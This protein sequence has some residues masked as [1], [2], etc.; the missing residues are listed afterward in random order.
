MVV[1]FRSVSLGPLCDLSATVP[2]GAVVG[3]IALNDSGQEQ[4]LQLA[5]GAAS[6]ASGGV[7]AH[8]PRRMLGPYDALDLDDV[9]TVALYHTLSLQDSLTRAKAAVQFEKMRRRGAS[10]LLA[11]HE[12]ELLLRLCDEIWWLEG[13]RLAAK[14]DPGE[15]LNAYQRHVIRQ[16]RV[17]G[18]TISGEI[19]PVMRRVDGRALLLDLE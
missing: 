19:P 12:P 18:A 17:W 2:D 16:Q 9:E 6:P 11:S 8:W 4:V 1:V 15:T 14:G 10:I 7:D 3:V 5:G 13:G